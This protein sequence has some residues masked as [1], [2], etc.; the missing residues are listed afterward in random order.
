M[1]GPGGGEEGAF[2]AYAY[3]EPD[4]YSTARVTPADA[5]YSSDYREFLLP[6]ETV[7]TAPHPD[8]TGL[9]FLQS[10][11]EAAADTGRW[12][13]SALEYLPVEGARPGR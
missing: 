12:D 11:Y 6:Y 13:R 4:G 10:T 8:A 1:I 2:Y 9:G 5:F 3:P 7:R